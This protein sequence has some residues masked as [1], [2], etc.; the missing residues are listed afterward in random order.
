MEN[1]VIKFK[2]QFIDA[3]EITID[4]NTEFRHLDSYDS[5]TG[6]A[7]IMMIEDEYDVK[8]EDDVY[9]KLNTPREIFNYLKQK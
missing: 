2:D 7:I 1:F 9:K 6:M 5:L 4:E 8:I 3:D